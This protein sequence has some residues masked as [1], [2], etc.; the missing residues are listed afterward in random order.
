MDLLPGTS[1]FSYPA[2]RGSFYPAGM[3]PDAMLRFYAERFPSVEINNTFYRMPLPSVLEA[4]ASQV[5]ETFRFVLKAPQRIT[6]MKRL[7]NID[8]EL[9]R[10]LEVAAV[11]SA[12]RGPLLFQLPPNFRKDAG[13]LAAFL[14]KLPR[15]VE[16]AF[17]FRH[18]TWF[19][20]EVRGLLGARG[21]ALCIADDEDGT[22]PHWATARFGYAR[23]RR[24]EY[25]PADLQAWAAKLREQPWDRAYVFF[26][27]E[28]EGRGPELASRFREAWAG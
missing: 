3:K 14:E 22:A 7:N 8:D 5:G 6:H 10:F 13:R 24:P 16:A 20:D 26:K 18:A 15:D 2:W 27:H 9:T 12:K 1:G 23:L 11:L 4:W 21:V 25:T 17:E 19:D 28:D